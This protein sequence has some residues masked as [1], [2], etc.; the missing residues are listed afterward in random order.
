LILDENPLLD[1]RNTLSL[2]EVMKNGRLYDARTLDELWP[3]RRPLPP[4]WFWED[5]PA[6]SAPEGGSS[7]P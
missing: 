5:G 3:R 2:R 4:L 1:I 7:L 6:A